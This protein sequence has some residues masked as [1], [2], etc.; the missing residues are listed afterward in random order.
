MAI[1]Y[2]TKY[3]N[4][5]YFIDKLIF[6]SELKHCH[7]IIGFFSLFFHRTQIQKTKSTQ[8]QRWKR[9]KTP[10]NRILNGSIGSFEGKFASVFFILSKIFCSI[11]VFVICIPIPF[12]HCLY[13]ITIGYI[14]FSLICEY[15]TQTLPI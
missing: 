2:Y 10:P 7:F 3:S 1:R 14:Y 6:I 8:S 11:K 13:I 9:R 12:I 15:C 4:E 5:N